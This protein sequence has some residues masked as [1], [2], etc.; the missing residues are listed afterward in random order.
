M[1]YSNY[2]S[3]HEVIKMSTY[4]Y[5]HVYSNTMYQLHEKITLSLR[6]PRDG[7]VHLPVSSAQ[8][9]VITLSRTTL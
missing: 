1:P 2:N 5:N 4:E 8:C 7:H 9:I 3:I 6:V